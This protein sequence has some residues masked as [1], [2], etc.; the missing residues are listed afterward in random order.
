MIK[1]FEQFCADVY[2]RPVNEAFQSSKLRELIK[3]HGKPKYSWENKML[4]D[5]KDSEIV[6]V[7]D[8]RDEY[9]EKYDKF[10]QDNG[11]A[12]F[13]LE[14]EDGTCIV[15]GNLGI[16]KRYWDIDKMEQEM[17][18]VFKDRHSKRHKGNLGKDGDDIHRKHMENVNKIMSKRLAEELQ[19][20]IPEIVEIVKTT[21]FSMDMEDM[22]DNDGSI[23]K[24][25][26]INDK[27]YILTISYD[28][29]CDT[30]REYGEEWY[31]LT[32]SINSFELCELEEDLCVS[33]ELLGVTYKTHDDLFKEYTE[34]VDGGVY[35]PYL[36]YGVSEKDFF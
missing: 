18:E 16:L 2:S 36:A 17:K 27:E 12:T 10:E 34:K 24:E 9:Y 35:D 6:D 30:Y 22:E 26:K 19:S 31:N 32:Y 14:L 1:T 29:S 13:K 23:E 25:I 11:E 4:Y 8:N 21:M 33:N 3:Q 28:Y 7:L 15:I 20:D 5:L